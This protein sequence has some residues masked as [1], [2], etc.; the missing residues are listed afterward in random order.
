MTAAIPPKNGENVRASNAPPSTAVHTEKDHFAFAK[1]NTSAA[2]A[3]NQTR[4][5]IEKSPLI[6]GRI[7]LLN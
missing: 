6:R 7:L 1:P 3:I 4:N 2:M 5:I